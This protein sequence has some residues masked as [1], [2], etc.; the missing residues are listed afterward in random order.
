VT[1]GR[2]AFAI[3][4]AIM[5]GVPTV[6]PRA[7][8]QDVE[9]PVI[10]LFD[11]LVTRNPTPERE[12]EI[13]VEYANGDEG[14]EVEAEVELSW[15]FGRRFS[16]GVEIPLV[17]LMP[18]EGSNESGLGD[19]VLGGKV[20]LFQSIGLPALLTTGLDLG[21]P[22]GS[23]SRGLGGDFSVAPYL[24]GGIAVGPIDL[25]GDVSYAWAVD[26]SDEGAEF[27]GAS[28]AAGYRG[29]RTVTPTLELSILTQTRSATRDTRDNGDNGEPDEGEAA[30]RIV[31][32]TQV[33]LTP[34]VVVS[35]PRRT[36][37]RTGVQFALMDA[38]EFDYRVI[39]SWQWEF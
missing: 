5:L 34:G 26:G 16:A 10:E 28:V 1:R 27:F 8:A 7:W 21:L 12:F 15:F 23:E 24:A 36:T 6:A 13:T 29:W 20:L 33:Y 4:L 17:F 32:K 19:I 25:I 22:T 11:P 31:G 9:Q 3:T 18:E 2:S 37:V 14:E 35:L 38:R 30:E 39:A